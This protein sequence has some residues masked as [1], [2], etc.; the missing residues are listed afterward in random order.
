MRATTTTTAGLGLAAVLTGVLPAQALAERPAPPAP[1]GRAASAAPSGPGTPGQAALAKY[2]TQHLT[3]TACPASQKELNAAGARCADVTVPLDYAD[4]HGRTIKVAVSRIKA[5]AP[6]SERRGVLLS[7]PGGPGGTGLAYTLALRPALKDVAGRYDLIG[8]DPRFLGASTPITCDP[9]HRPAPPETTSP[10]ADFE[11]AVR[12]GREDARRCHARGDNAALLPGASSRNVARDMDVIRAALGQRTLSYYGVSYGADLGAAYAQLFPRRVDRFVIDSV[13]DP[14][15][16]QYEQFQR[17]GAPAERALDEWAAWTAR[18]HPTYRLG[19]SARAVRAR[20][21]EV[22][23]HAERRPL[24]VAGQRLTAPLLRMI[25][26]QPLTQQENDPLVA[27]LVRDLVAA[28]R[29]E[30]TE[31][32]PELAA[33]LKMLNSPEAADS[34]LGGTFFMCG[35]GGWP[36]GGWPTATETYWR[37]SVRSRA[38]EPV[39]G[40]FVNGITAPC[41]FFEKP[42]REPG[43]TVDNDVPVLMLQ[44]RRDHTR[45]ADALAMHRAL[46]GSR[47]VATDIRGHGVYGRE[48][49]GLTRVPCAERAVNDYLGGGELPERDRACPAPRVGRPRS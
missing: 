2:R 9:A 24:A 35:D 48:I 41:Q 45:F 17:S 16:T 30:L 23:T 18:H 6:E 34:M 38:T 7:N 26:K 43:V 14:A 1:A 27:S 19:R 25:L 39:F 40:P 13:T 4:P 37:N 20:V 49:D 21:E 12:D 44:A 33:M 3:W 36:A 32:G 10:R 28:D 11:A 46:R 47:L 29:G 15:A 5:T 22:L 8:F 42:P 31:P